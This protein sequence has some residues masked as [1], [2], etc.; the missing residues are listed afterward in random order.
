MLFTKVVILGL[1]ALVAAHPG[2]E[3]AEYRHAVE[4]RANARANR[5]ALEGCAAKL[6]ERGVTTRAVERRKAAV[7][8]HRKAKRIPVDG[9]FC[10]TPF[11]LLSSVPIDLRCLPVWL[12]GN[13]FIKIVEKC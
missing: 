11:P 6:Q 9:V 10:S 8:K 3:E 5:R 1:A 2:H 13:A 7:A 12:T 4:S